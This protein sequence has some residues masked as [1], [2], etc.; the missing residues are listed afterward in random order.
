[1]RLHEKYLITEKDNIKQMLQWVINA[2][3]D[4]KIITKAKR[5]MRNNKKNA[6][7]PMKSAQWLT[8]TWEGMGKPRK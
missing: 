2:T 6:G 3:D 7:I 8:D 4:S 1:M 5:L